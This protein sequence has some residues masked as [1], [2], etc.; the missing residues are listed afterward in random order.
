[1]IIQK[2]I[3]IFLKNRFHLETQKNKKALTLHSKFLTSGLT[4]IQK[5]GAFCPGYP[6]RSAPYSF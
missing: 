6:R 5:A 2:R 3:D 1:L 4:L